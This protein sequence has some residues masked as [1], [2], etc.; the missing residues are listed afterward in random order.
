MSYEETLN[1]R[2]P[3][4]LND[5]MTRTTI[6]S[7]VGRVEAVAFVI[8][9][10]AIFSTINADQLTPKERVFLF[11]FA[12][13]HLLVA[14][15]IV[16]IGGPF[17]NG[18]IWPFL[19]LSAVWAAPVM[20]AEFVPQGNYGIS[21][22][23]PQ[24]CGYPVSPVAIAAFYPWVGNRYNPMSLWTKAALAASIAFEPLILMWSVNG[25]ITS[26]NLQGTLA[27][28]IMVAG[29]WAGGEAIGRICR[30]A[31]ATQAAA[32]RREYDRQFGYL[33]SDIETGL[34]VAEIGYRD[35]RPDEVLAALKDLGTAVLDERMRLSLAQDYV[36]VADIIRL[37]VRR[38]RDR[39]SIE[40][41]PSVDVI[42]LPQAVATLLSNA[43]GDL[44]KNSLMYGAKRVWIKFELTG[45]NAV[46]EIS[47]DGPGFSPSILDDASNS[48]HA[49]RSRAREFRGDLVP[50]TPPAAIAGAA[51]RLTFVVP[52]K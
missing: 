30:R 2:R 16:R 32:L 43:L 23:C 4:P 46:L 5:D 10:F 24:L 39:I 48:L 21:P 20:M 34:C 29:M 12:A 27:Q 22:V 1:Q 33:H 13:A 3:V 7:F 40:G 35:N 9:A 18:G 36:S 51:L 19:W 25:R 50:L 6:R 8:Q 52:K 28:T 37:H 42:T 17:Y 41:V 11:G 45:D 38:V 49:L 31:A 26:Y 15:I 44:L 14:A 47:D